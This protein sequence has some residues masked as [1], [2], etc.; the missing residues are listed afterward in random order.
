MSAT[1][2]LSRGPVDDEGGRLA[3]LDQ[4]NQQLHTAAI[5]PMKG[6]THVRDITN[7]LALLD[8]INGQFI[9][10]STAVEPQAMTDRM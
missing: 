8:V 2:R 5:T 9:S 4:T 1:S 3:S 10:P 6:I 7:K